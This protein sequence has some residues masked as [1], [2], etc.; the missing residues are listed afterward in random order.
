MNTKHVLNQRPLIWMLATIAVCFLTIIACGGSRS[1]HENAGVASTSGMSDSVHDSAV[2]SMAGADMALET[3]PDD[4][5]DEEMGT[6]QVFS[7][8]DDGTGHLQRA[9]S[10][11]DEAMGTDQ[12]ISHMDDGAGGHQH[13]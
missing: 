4:A 5:R 12:V 8:M 2:E 9:Q 1:D 13:A 3:H 10:M 11:L 6:D 7:H